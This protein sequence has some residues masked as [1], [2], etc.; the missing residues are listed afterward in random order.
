MHATVSI[1]DV[2]PHTLEGVRAL[3]HHIPDEKRHKVLL[4]IVPGVEWTPEQIDKLKRFRDEGFLFAGHGWQHRTPHIRGVYHRLHSL[5]ISRNVAEHL[6]YTTDELTDLLRQNYDWFAQQGLP[7]PE[8]YAPPAWAM[9][10]LTRKHLRE[11]PF[12]YY[13]DTQGFYDSQSDNYKRLPLSGFEADTWLRENFLRLWNSINRSLSSPKKPLR[14]SLHPYDLD[15]RV[16]D[17]LQRFI[18][19]IEH[20]Y[21]NGDI[22]GNK[23]LEK[24][25]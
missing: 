11:L 20:W 4:L 21:S 25:D 2:M 16:S 19:S 24:C 8:T 5:L 7:S 1:H 3:I 12:R 22:F 10:K 17:Q 15:Y 23:C 9:G 18:R 6:S 13:E 14:I